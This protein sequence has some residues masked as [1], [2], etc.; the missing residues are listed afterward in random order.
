MMILDT[1]NNTPSTLIGI[2]RLRAL[3][4]PDQRAFTFLVNGET[5]GITVTYEELDRQARIIGS[6]LQCTISVGERALLLYQPGPEYIAAF[7]G[8][9]YAGVIAIPAYPPQSARPDRTLTR[10]LR[11]IAIDCQA[12]VVLTQTSFVPIFDKLAE[13]MAEFTNITAI[14]TDT[15]S[16][17]S[18]TFWQEPA[19]TGQSLAFLQYTSGSTSDP[20]G[21]MLTHSNLLHNSSL[22][23]RYFAHTP[24]S[25]GVI[26]LPPYHDMGLIGGILQPIYGGFPVTLLSPVAFL[27]RPLRWLE[28]ISREQATTS[29]GP[30]FAYDLCVSKSTPEQRAKLDLSSWKVAFSGA[31]PVRTTT[32]T[33][34]VEA[35]APSGFHKKAFYPCYGLAEATLIVTGGQSDTFPRISTFDQAALQLNQASPVPADHSD[36]VSLVSNGQSADDQR[37]VIVDPTTITEC[38]PGQVGEIWVSG[39]SVAQGYWRKP[40]LTESTLRAQLPSLP[41]QTFLRTGDSGFLSHHELFITGRLKDLIIIRGRNHYPQDIELTVEQSHQALRVNS[42]AAFS[43]DVDA[44]EQ[45][46]I[47]QE[48]ER[49]E[50]NLDVAQ[51]AATIR[52]AVAQHH[53]LQVY[54]IIFIKTGTIL[55]TS[56]GKIQRS[57]CREKYLAG[58]FESI[59]QSKQDNSAAFTHDEQPNLTR[60][61]ILEASSTAGPRLLT[62]YLFDVLRTIAQVPPDALQSSQTLIALGLDSLTA[63]EVQY[64]LENTLGVQVSPASFLDDLSISQLA[65]EI[66][67]QL[68]F[69]DANPPVE[70]DIPA[71][72]LETFFPLSYG[73]RA[74]WFLQKL[75]AQNTANTLIS[76]MSIHGNINLDALRKSFQILG[77]RHPALRTIFVEREGVPYQYIQPQAQFS[78]E[79]ENGVTWDDRALQE[80]I[81][82]EAQKPFNLEQGPLFRVHLFLRSSTEAVFLFAIHHLITDFWSLAILLQELHDLYQAEKTQKPFSL[83]PVESQY[84]DFVHSQ[85]YLLESEQGQQ[86][87]RYWHQQLAG[88]L[89]VLNLPCDYPRPTIQTY[90]GCMYPF[91]LQKELT[92]Q[93]KHVAKAHGLTLYMLLLACWQI[94]LHRYTGQD[95]ILVGSPL[96]GRSSAKWS[97]VIGYFVNPVV[98]RG[99]ITDDTALQDFFAQVRQTVLEA[100]SHQDYPFPLLVEQLQADRDP[101][102]SPLFQTMF[103]LEKSHLHSH[104]DISLS[105]ANPFASLLQFGDLQAELLPIE[106]Q[107][108]QFD[109]SLMME[110]TNDTLAA[111]LQYN[112]DLFTKAT[113]VQMS[114]HFQMIL[115]GIAQNKNTT[116][117]RLALLTPEEIQQFKQ[118]NSTQREYPPQQVLHTRFQEQVKRTPHAPALLVGEEQFSYEQLNQRANRLAHLLGSLGVG[119]E[120]LVAICLPRT[121]DLLIAIFATLKAGGAYVPLDPNYPADRLA[122]ILGDTQPQVVLT[123]R[124]LLANLPPVHAPLCLDEWEECLANQPEHDPAITVAPAN[125]AYLIYTS[126][127]TGRPKGVAI[128]HA[129]ATA[130]IEWATHFFTREHFD[131]VLAA[132]SVC[133]DLS[134][135]EL[136][137]P[138]SCG[139]RVI[140]AENI[141]HLPSLSAASQVSL[142]NM[143]PSAARELSRLGPL[144]ATVHTITL[145]GETLSRELAD[146]LYEHPSVQEVYNLYGPSEDTTYSTVALIPREETR[147]PTIG[148]P[149]ANGQVY[150]LDPQGQRVPVGVVGELY[151]G[152]AR[153]ARGYLG[154]PDLTAER[155]VPHPFSD[156]PGARLYRTGDLARFRP[157]GS[158]DFLGRHDQQVKI[159]GFRIELGEI[160]AVLQAHPHVQNNAVLMRQETAMLEPHLVAY[161]V[162][163]LEE[164]CEISELRA[165]LQAR[166]PVYMLPNAYVLLETLPFMPNGKLNRGALPAPRDIDRLYSDN[167]LALPRNPLEE[168]LVGIWAEVLGHQNVSIYDNFFDLGGHSLLVTQVIARI[169]DIYHLEVPLIVLFEAKTIEQLAQRIQKLQQT[170]NSALIIPLKPQYSAIG[171]HPLSL[172]QQRLWLLHQIDN[173]S[174]A[175][176]IPAVI[177]LRGRVDRFAIRKSL[178]E[179]IHR[180]ATLRTTFIQK[181]EEPVQVVTDQVVLDI[182]QRDLRYLPETQRYQEALAILIKESRKPFDLTSGPLFRVF[183]IQLADDD[184]ILSITMHHIIADGWSLDV[185]SREFTDLYATFAQ[186]SLPTLPPLAVQYTDFVYWQRAYFHAA[187]QEQQLTYWKR[188]LAGSAPLIELPLDYPRPPIQTFRGATQTFSLSTDLTI[189]LRNLSRQENVTLYMTL[190]AAFQ[191]LLYRY[192]GQHDIVIGSPL[193]NRT[194]KQTEG[195]I[196]LFV[197]T[198]VMRTELDD[199]LSF[200][201]LLK[202]VRKTTLEAYTHQDLPFERLVEALQPQRSLSYSPIFQVL[203]TLQNTHELKLHQDNLSIERIDI[204]TG[205]AKFDLNMTIE[206]HANKLQGWLEYNT[207]LFHATTIQRLLAH[208]HILL[209]AI[210]ANKQLSI[211]QLSLLTPEEIQQFKQWNSTQREYPPQQVLHTRFQEQVR[212]TPHAPALLVGEEQFTYEQ[213]NQRAN[214]LAHLFRSLGVGPECLVAICLPRTADLLIAI[215]ATL[216]AG[217]AYVP[218]D[219]DYPADR[220]AFMLEDTE[221]Q[222]VLTQRKLLANLPPVHAPLCLDEWEECLANQPEHDPAI[223]VAPANLAYLIYTS[224]STGRPKGVVITHANATAFIEWA[225]HFFTHEQLEGVLAATSVCFDISIFDIFAPLSS[226]GCVILAENVL[227][228]PTL[229]AASRVTLM[230]TVPSAAHELLRLGPLLPGIKT[231]ALGGEAL[232]GEL[233]HQFY[234]QPQVR[235]VYNVYGPSEDTTYSTVGLI[236]RE[237]THAPTIG[238]PIANGQVYLLNSQGQPVPVGVVG[239][240]YLG[241]AGLARGYLGR[242]DLT[243]ERFVPH[244][245]SDQPGQRLYRTGDL[246]RFRSDGSLDFLGRRDHQVKVHGFRVELGEIEAVLLAHP[247]VQHCVV[248]ARRE[249]TV[250]EQ[251]L[252]AYVVPEPELPE[253]ACQIAELRA[254]LQAR[255]PAY[256]LPNAYVLLEALPLTP[257]GKLKRDALPVP[258]TNRLGLSN[259]LVAPRTVLEQQL[260]SFWQELLPVAQVGIHDNFFDAGGH[261]LLATQLISRL[262]AHLQREIPL[263]TLFEAPTIAQL[264]MR[265][266]TLVLPPFSAAP[267][268]LPINREQ[269]IPLSFA[270]QRLWMLEQLDPH[271]ALYSISTAVAIDGP[272]EMEALQQALTYLVAR[273]ESLRTTFHLAATQP[274]QRIISPFDVEVPLTDLRHL[275][276]EQQAQ[277]VQQ[278]IKQE[279]SYGFHLDRG[280]LFQV[281]VLQLGPTQYLLAFTMHHII[282]DAW[283]IAIFVR[284]LLACYRMFQHGDSPQLL[285]LPIQYADYAHW[286]RQWLQGEALKELQAY[287]REQLCEPLPPLEL[288]TDRPRPIL[289]SFVGAQYAVSLPPK[290]TYALRQ[291]SQQEGVSLFMTLLASFQVLLSRY[292]G[293]TDVIVGTPIANRTQIQIER[294]IGCFINTLALRVDLAAS[295]T[296]RELLQQVREV[297]L[298]AYAH[299]D[300]PFEQLVEEVQT[301]RDLSRNPI[302]QV[303]F[304]LQN[305]SEID[306]TVP[307]LNIQ[308]VPVDTGT[309]K[310]DLTLSLEEKEN[311]LQGWFEY[312]THLFDTATIVRLASHF[313]TLLTSICA[314]PDRA[315]TQLSMLTSEEIQLFKRWNA[316]QQEYP[317]QRVL[318]TCFQEQVQHTPQAPA[319]LVGEEQFTYEQLNQRANRLAHLLVS[320]GVGP[321]R[322]VAICLPRTSD[323]LIAIL[324]T[325]KAGGAYLPLDPNYPADRLAFMLND[326]RPQVVLTRTALLSLLPGS[327]LASPPLCLDTIEDQLATLPDDDPQVALHPTN[328]A[329]LIYTSGSTGRP[330][331]VVITHANATGF[332]AWAIHFFSREQLGGVLATTSVCFDLSI[333]ELFAP[334]SCG[335][336]VILVENVLHLPSLPAAAQVSL[337]NM[338]PSAAHELSRLGPLPATVHTITLAGEPLTRE[339]A[340]QLYEHPPVQEVYNLYGP[341]EDTTYST[342]ALIPREETHAPTIGTPIANGEVYLLDPQRQLV[343]VGVVGELYLGGA[344]LARGYLDRPDLTAERFVPHPFSDQPGA[345]LYRTGD[346]A[347]FRPDGSLDFLG[348]RDQQVKVRGFRI[349]LGEI[350]HAIR[351]HP[352]VN[353]AVVDVYHDKSGIASLI[354]YIVLI[355]S[356]ALTTEE[357]YQILSQKL[358]E[359]MVPSIFQFL[360]TLPLTA[361]GKIDR[362]RLPQPGENRANPLPAYSPPG[363]PLEEVVADLWREVLQMDRIGIHD[364][365]F[366]I[367]GN[368]LHLIQILSRLHQIFQLEVPMLKAMQD[369]TVQKMAHL[370]IYYEKKPGQTEHTARI[371]QKLQ[372]MPANEREKLLQ[373]RRSGR[374]VS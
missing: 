297:T 57:A 277:Q 136:F 366:T 187:I 248:L 250:T 365:F 199:H 286:Q 316:T 247:Q 71:H 234:Q 338:V 140:L 72:T 118:W 68:S 2:L 344:G 317:S 249:S 31:E 104:R 359:Y 99:H 265:L 302:F 262:R 333:F 336:R 80:R 251:Q 94:L 213:L 96:A 28:A 240:L 46:V 75:E 17:G 252:V 195:L 27:Q 319:L 35:F 290:L 349:E 20:K 355:D 347:R 270:Q 309:A 215:L 77:E 321:E 120:R 205:T 238:T 267:A 228:L 4:Q 300:L 311:G 135:F 39:A 230:T 79:I 114:K 284:E 285:P 74:L 295:P 141:L 47:V 239:E 173:Q 16:P 129:N 312:N 134:I 70:E 207:D 56:S 87:Q 361:N 287:W 301:G 18:E 19:I 206:E 324:A 204:D 368:S 86:I 197:N 93:L 198:L 42:G 144:P 62:S 137:A 12:S 318:H 25:K 259:E 231:V 190:L 1:Q 345:R 90:H 89:P 49:S 108:A 374:S 274:V 58:Q 128:T 363:T 147:V 258:T 232:P 170:E 218:L 348:R 172:A 276:S 275:S 193:A 353:T 371:L 36:A 175:Y 186:G 45:L 149:I 310:F 161:V 346:L 109:L 182:P 191:V 314:Y 116:V 255:L 367:G 243:A 196:G 107:T 208:F 119:P 337:L 264:A 52:Q 44:T 91:F 322:L 41:S 203:F 253:E 342:V 241:G 32:M 369:A 162:P 329:Y 289:Q 254:W 246:A 177:R 271:S 123:Q 81:R 143:V 132:T 298:E 272:L 83:A 244:P 7:F 88:E 78:F 269:D 168:L 201:E 34:F 261:S 85:K 24:E 236:P 192:S 106:Q 23:Q 100:I 334:L 226:G 370:L 174:P 13:K 356:H 257:N 282:S 357:L 55:K 8:C 305:A 124:R 69:I 350:E 60:N 189:A 166:L 328:L 233:A 331:G 181:N 110:E 288:P 188:Q 15:L 33:R 266:S 3:A 160:E 156:Q 326:A 9:L 263:R 178:T 283:S 224:G 299:Q 332:I 291:M 341:S 92:Q 43:I 105:I 292:S 148:T 66:Y 67:Q 227:H 202:R 145:C 29:G 48:V 184:V 358:P 151:L 242:P 138:L 127:S 221:P 200:R 65:D 167:S 362:H 222:V 315:I 260:A 278:L 126:G 225:T 304:I 146:Q 95:E 180:H 313:Q 372:N 98:I 268:L 279:Y 354:A 157:D 306:L 325:L 176:H 158:L 30:N 50:R 113:A 165:W 339:L 103:V 22:I 40:E 237:E 163:E 59:G 209:Q 82:E 343:P 139:G 169:R 97:G 131:G 235:G 26:W 154:R 229:P 54:D 102:R 142:L 51:V 11:T 212:R 373:S 5:E 64:K 360:E 37:L 217:G 155:F 308:I 273:H 150:L 121:A 303:M 214:R 111:S 130:F 171:E 330:K 117:A 84:A 14:A 6:V 351:Q 220:L 152:G 179:I 115:A 125:L 133:F 183:T 185:L 122:F 21:V 245:F 281:Q 61:D 76:A 340:D 296:F 194:Q 73:Q 53:D 159:R 323:L 293:Q 219:P 38:L 223:T 10:R 327:R 320:L 112:T 210:L 335:G 307:G 352:I 364:N 101:G 256:M 216:K 280:P 211:A 294:L 153:L 164:P 63:I